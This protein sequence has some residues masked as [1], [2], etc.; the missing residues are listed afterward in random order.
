MS[1]KCLSLALVLFLLI[2]SIAEAKSMFEENFDREQKELKSGGRAVAMS[3]AATAIPVV[4]GGTFIYGNSEG[5]GLTLALGGLVLGPGTGH[6]YAEQ[7]GRGLTGIG[8]RLGVALGGAY[9]IS[10]I[11]EDLHP[12]TRVFTEGI[13]FLV[14]SSAILAHGIYDIFT[15]P[16][17][18][19]KYNE[20]LL[21]EN[22]LRLVPEINL[23]NES[24]GLSIVYNF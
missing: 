10:L 9:L 7:T 23:V 16:S 19:R 8:I 12:D 14:V 6:F 13:G 20:S 17:S 21:E 3:L 4:L 22:S 18:V 11:K 2:S 24:Y 15:T 5:F 1:K